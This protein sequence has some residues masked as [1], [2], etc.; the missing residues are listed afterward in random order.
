MRVVKRK[1]AFAGVLRAR[2]TAMM[3]AGNGPRSV[4]EVPGRVSI[5]IP[6]A[7]Y[8]RSAQIFLRGHFPIYGASPELLTWARQW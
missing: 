1:R 5:T 7:A 3:S 8:E 4:T 2:V 6:R